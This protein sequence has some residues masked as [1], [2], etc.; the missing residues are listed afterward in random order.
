[1]AHLSFVQITKRVD[2]GGDTYGGVNNWNWISTGD[3]LLNGAFFSPS[4]ENN[5]APVYGKASSLSARPA[6]LVQSLTN[7]AGPLMCGAGVC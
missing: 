3:M 4:G 7:D 5:G 2:D 1:M 6:A